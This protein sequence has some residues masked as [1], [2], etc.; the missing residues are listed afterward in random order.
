NRG[1]K[2]PTKFLPV[3]Q[4]FFVEVVTDLGDIE[5]NNSQR[6]FKRESAGESVF[7]RDATETAVEEENTLNETQILRLEFGVSSGASRSFVLGFSEQ[8]TDGFDYGYDGGLITNPP[9]DDMG[10]LLDGQQ[11]V[12]QAFAPITPDKEVDLVLHAS[13]NYT[14]SLKS[15]E[16][17]NIPE[18]QPLFIRDNLTGNTF[19]LRSAQQ[20]DFTSVAGSFTDRFQVIFE[21]PTLS[22]P[23]LQLNNILVFVNNDKLFVKGVEDQVKALSIINMLGQNVKRYNDVSHDV[24]KNGIDISGLSTGMYVVSLQTTNKLQHTQKVVKE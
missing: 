21:D 15:T 17:T 8:T 13:G 7:L 11:Y 1:I 3:G 14:Y 20:Y 23:D 24:L 6:T 9:A 5:F 19:D 10:S 22:T 16:I 2:T 18:S 12:I 4:G